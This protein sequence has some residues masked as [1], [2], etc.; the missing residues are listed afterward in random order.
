MKRN[1]VQVLCEKI[2]LELPRAVVMFVSLSKTCQDH[3]L[4]IMETLAENCSP[5][6][7]FAAFM[8]VINSNP[9]FYKIVLRGFR[10]VIVEQR[11]LLRK[12]V[13]TNPVRK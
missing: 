10:V 9:Q 8:E 4:S 11:T 6:E 13:I 12:V 7:M 1:C 2:G 5:R 3:C